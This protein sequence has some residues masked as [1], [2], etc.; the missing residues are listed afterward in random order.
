MGTELLCCIYIGR[1]VAMDMLKSDTS[2]SGMNVA[3]IQASRCIVEKHTFQTAPRAHVSLRGQWA[4][5]FCE[6][7][8]KTVPQNLSLNS[9]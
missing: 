2:W 9:S 4:I 1:E 6:L 3:L 8:I 7:K 5:R